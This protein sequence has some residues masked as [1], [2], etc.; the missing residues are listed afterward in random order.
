MSEKNFKPFSHFKVARLDAAATLG[1]K[2]CDF[3]SFSLISSSSYSLTLSQN[4]QINTCKYIYDQ[5]SLL[6]IGSV[7]K[8]Q[9]SLKTNEKLRGLLPAAEAEPRDSGLAY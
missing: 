7:Y 3:M 1:S 8:Q 6:V 4:H 5:Q 2:N 9:L